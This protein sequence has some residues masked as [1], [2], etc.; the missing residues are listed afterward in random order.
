MDTPSKD[1]RGRQIR[2]D[3]MAREGH[4][5]SPLQHQTAVLAPVRSCVR[6][7]PVLC[8][9]EAFSINSKRLAIKRECLAREGRAEWLADSEFAF[10]AV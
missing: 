4:P 10:D 5:E 6:L 7:R 2:R 8:E 1:R 3:N 9:A